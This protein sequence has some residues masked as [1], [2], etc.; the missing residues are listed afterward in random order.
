MEAERKAREE[1][2]RKVEQ[3]RLERQRLIAKQQAEAEITQQAKRDL[4]E[5][6]DETDKADLF[7]IEATQQKLK[8]TEAKLL[9]V[10][11]KLAGVIFSDVPRL[12]RTC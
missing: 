5:I 8:E 4:E 1:A 2:A 7:D 9:E 3:E 10:Q 12:N 6:A 11:S